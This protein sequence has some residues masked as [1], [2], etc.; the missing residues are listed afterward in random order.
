MQRS[1]TLPVR[2]GGGSGGGVTSGGA[3]GGQRTNKGKNKPPSVSAQFNVS[4]NAHAQS[5]LLS[6]SF[7]L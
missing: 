4:M 7:R 2:G 1:K 6:F 3:G 5:V